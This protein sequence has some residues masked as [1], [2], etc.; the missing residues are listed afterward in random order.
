[1]AARLGRRPLRHAGSK[2]PTRAVSQPTFCR[3]AGTRTAPSARTNTEVV[4]SKPI[5]P[6]LLTTVADGDPKHG[7]AVL[8]PTPEAPRAVGTRSRSHAWKRAS[9]PTPGETPAPDDEVERHPR[10]SARHRTARR[11]GVERGGPDL[12]AGDIGT[13]QSDVFSSGADESSSGSGSFGAPI[14]IRASMTDEVRSTADIDSRFSD[15]EAGPDSRGP[16]PSVCSNARSCTS[17]DRADRRSA[18]CDP[19]E[20][21]AGGRNGAFR[22]RAPRAQGPR[23]RRRQ[24]RWR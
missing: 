12:C 18:A 13:G 22:Q 21:R 3:T 8:H 4:P 1:M 7:R 10:A 2:R 19:A 14:R 16:T 6:T 20:R 24:A 17:Y 11:A 23:A 9:T 15:P 5:L